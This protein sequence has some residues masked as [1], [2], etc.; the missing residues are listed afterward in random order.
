MCV[1]WNSVSRSYLQRRQLLP[2]SSLITEVRQPP[3]PSLLPSFPLSLSLSLLSPLYLSHSSLWSMPGA[4][5]VGASVFGCVFM[6]VRLRLWTCYHVHCVLVRQA[7][8][9]VCVCIPDW[10]CFDLPCSVVFELE[11]CVWLRLVL[12]QQG[13]SADKTGVPGG[14]MKLSE[15]TTSL[16][17]Q[18]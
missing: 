5:V 14:H 2:H 7:R 6:S 18:W 3:S 8:V 17:W 15:V 9:F 16:Q 10:P 12:K 1:N 13:P 11:S 4:C